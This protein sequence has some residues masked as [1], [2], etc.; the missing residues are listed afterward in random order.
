MRNTVPEYVIG[1]VRVAAKAGFLTKRV[2]IEFFATGNRFWQYRRWQSLMASGLFQPVPEYG[3]AETAVTLTSAG[4]A[5]AFRLG[6]GP[7]FSPPAKNLWHDEE[8]V[9]LALF[10]ERQGWISNWLTEPALKSGSVGST[11]F[12]S[13]GRAPKYADLLLEWDTPQ[14]PVLW[15]VEL[16]RTRKEFTRY[17]DMVGAYKGISR[18]DSVLVIVA[19]DSIE[20]NIKKAQAKLNYP[21]SQ[22]PMVFASLSEIAKAP[23]TCELRQASAR[24]PLGGFAQ[25]LT[26]KTPTPKASQGKSEGN[27]V[28]NN[29]SDLIQAV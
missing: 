12:P 23:A 18:I 5:L 2:W 19:A 24:M 26:G 10:L 14:G 29:V 7:V 3:M 15:A 6:L 8:L 17:Y 21:Q 25:A 1:P 13:S 28:G 9:R 11:L 22:R 20:T 16:E 4:R 27:T